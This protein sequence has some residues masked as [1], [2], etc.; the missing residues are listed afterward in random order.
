MKE[1]VTGARPGPFA[2]AA[3]DIREHWV[4]SLFAI[5][6]IIIGVA[7]ISTL[8]MLGNGL[9][10][11]VS[12]SMRYAGDTIV[13]TPHVSASPGSAGGEGSG[14]MITEHQAGEIRRAAASNPVIPIRTGAE[15]ITVGSGAESVAVYAMAPADVPV[16]LE[17]AS[18]NY[19][20]YGSGVMAGKGLADATGL[21]VGDTIGIGAGE[22]RVRVTGILKERGIGFDLSPDDA[23]IVPDTWFAARYGVHDY[24]LVII[25][26]KNPDDIDAVKAAVDE[27]LNLR[28]PVVNILDTRRV[29]TTIVDSFNQVSAV[30]VT[31]GGISLAVAGVSLLSVMLMSV[32]ERAGEIG[33]IRSL[34]ATRS[35]VMRIFLSEALILG[36]A[37]S[38][39][40]GILSLAGGYLA[41]GGM[42]QTT[43]FLLVPATIVPIL[44]GMGFGIGVSLLAGIYPAWKAAMMSPAGAP[45]AR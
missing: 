36:L 39:A 6:G 14:L 9:A 2:T 31:A 4:R 42:L 15:R 13:I 10:L 41:S 17:K 3:R 32:T 30:V 43:K 7:A 28:D 29:L 23:L 40:G 26:V 11:S 24:D 8:G 18:G 20:R 44:T 37:G 5:V 34:G 25:R 12:D 35:E 19:L 1:A 16:L 21:S 22:E 33:V 27:Q 45:R 38:A